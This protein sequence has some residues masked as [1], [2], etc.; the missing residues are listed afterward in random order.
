MNLVE[1][2]AKLLE[3]ANSLGDV[4]AAAKIWRDGLL[5]YARIKLRPYQTEASD[6][7][8]EYVLSE[9]LYGNEITIMYC[10]QSG[11]TE[12]VAD[13]VLA[14]GT[15]YVVFL[16][17]DFNTG[18]FA[19]VQ[20]MITHVTRNRLRKR[21]ARV[22]KF[23]M[24]AAD[25]RQMAGEGL[26]SSIFVLKSYQNDREFSA[27]S[28]SA[29]ESADIIGETFNL[30]VIEQSELI[31]AM[32]LKNDIF[33]MGAEAG[34]VRILTGTASPYLKNDYF[35]KAIERWSVN[36][37][38]N[39]STS[40]WVKCVEWKEAA[41]YSRKYKTYVEKERDRMGEDSIEFQTQFNL[42]WMGLK[43]KFIGWED[44]A[45]L[46][47]DYVSVKDRLRFFG[48]D[49]AKENDSTVVTVIELDGI[50]KHIIGWLELQG[51]DYEVQVQKIAR[52]LEQFLPLRYG[53]IDI[54]ACGR[55]VY[56]FL[57]SEMRRRVKEEYPDDEEWYERVPL[58]EGY[59]GS[60]GSD[61]QMF[62]AMD[63]EFVHGRVFYPKKTRFRKEKNK[64]LEQMLDLERVYTGRK[65][66][67]THP[68]QHG[69]HDDYCY[70]LALAVY[71]LVEKSF[72]PG[73]AFVDL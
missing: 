48:I 65:L 66:K 27:R 45:L 63:R 54:V 17:K 42:R 69:R 30:M 39:T 33:P 4:V 52:W 44:L 50:Q 32:K 37:V 35:R 29:G 24:K 11:K 49:I 64:F 13:T 38:K 3:S 10:R 58:I 55:P 21:Y 51:T 19:P 18:L 72:S 62:K 23:L 68:K 16:W 28:L 31:N 5:K 43:V 61:D 60:P 20:S 22:K 70:S 2:T 15:F 67:L 56:D 40:D 59:Y 73:A 34:G 53:L 57:K 25:L 7:I 41:K 9:G 6:K 47:K 71:A 1:A 14:L 26:T 8:I 46:E 36:P 12:A